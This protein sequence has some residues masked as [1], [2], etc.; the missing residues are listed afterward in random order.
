MRPDQT[1]PG[2]DTT[3]VRSDGRQMP[4]RVDTRNERALRHGERAGS[5]SPLQVE[6]R[7]ATSWQDIKGRF[8][9]DPS[10]AISAA[11]ELVRLAVEERIRALKAEAAAI[12]ASNNND[13]DDDASSTE[14][15]RTRLLRY[16]EYCERLAR[17]AMH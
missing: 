12:C 2:I 6:D 5:P 8:V 15:L 11:E 3:N 14:A 1:D 7:S 16:Q 13:N 10:G 9:D 17:T 4:D